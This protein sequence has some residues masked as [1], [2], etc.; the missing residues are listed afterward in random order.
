MTPSLTLK[1]SRVKTAPANASFTPQEV[2]VLRSQIYQTGGWVLKHLDLVGGHP[3]LNYVSGGDRNFVPV[4]EPFLDEP[5]V[6]SENVVLC[7]IG[8]LHR[9][10]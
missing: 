10:R 7:P 8:H 4:K 1:L 2:V 9:Q 3:H 5:L 6:L